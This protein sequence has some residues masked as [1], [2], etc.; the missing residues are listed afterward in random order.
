MIF[1]KE[2][3]REWERATSKEWLVTNGLGGYASSTIIG[4]NTRRYHGLLIAPLNPPWNRRLLLSKLEEEIFLGSKKFQLSTNK[5]PNAIHPQG[6]LHLEQFRL[7]K[8]PTFVYSI[9]RLV[10]KKTIFMPHGKNAV[11]VSYE[12]Q[13]PAREN[14]EIIIYLLINS[15][16]FHSETRVEA[17]DWSFS[18]EAEKSRVKIRAS[19]SNAPLLFLNSDKMSYE[20]STLPEQQRWY[21][22]M[23]YEQEKERCFAYHED[24]YCPGFFKL[25]TNENAKFSMVAS[26]SEEKLNPQQEYR[27]AV[28]RFNSLISKAGIKD[29][30]K[31]LTAASDS[32]IVSNSGKN[33]IAGYHWFSIWGRD[34]LISLPGLCLVTHRYRDAKKILQNFASYCNGT[35]PNRIMQSSADYHSADTS[36]WFFYAV[37]KYLSYTND[38][39]FAGKILKT[40]EDIVAR[41]IEGTPDIRCGD[42]HL[43]SAGPQMTWMDTKAT[44]REGKSVEVN[45]LWFNA[46]KILQLLSEKFGGDALKYEKLSNKVKKSFTAFWNGSY[47]CDVIK[48]GYRDASVRPNQIFA[49]SLPFSILDREKEKKVVQKVMEE[50]LTPYGLRSLSPKERGY[51]GIYS[52]SPEERDAAYHNSTVWSWLIG[53]FVTA[54]LKVNGRESMEQAKEFCMPLLAHTEDAGLGSISEIFDGDAPHA[55][56]GC[57]SQAWSV[58]ELLRCYVEDIMYKRPR[59]EG[60][61]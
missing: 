15:R 34:A 9:N 4:A 25:S 18:Q 45:A 21:R 27:K 2:T 56:R 17:I 55:A 44:P 61:I 5:Y 1:G 43:I 7:D 50:L 31:Y 47:L 6:Y 41:Y 12:L 19:Y 14:V 10:I 3:L 22:N 52:G 36:L 58:A 39:K 13:N 38:C 33:I 60:K 59:F 51:K 53:P 49:V 24:H 29:N 26:T 8:F 11:I 46:L 42:D 28:S 35:I 30:L 37:Y 48:D 57:I 16:Y 20:A 54:F 32:F 40:L 23:E